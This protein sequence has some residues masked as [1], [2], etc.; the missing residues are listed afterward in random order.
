MPTVTATEAR[1]KLYRLIDQAASS[2]EP[3]IITGKRANAVLISED[4]W[5]AIQETLYLLSISGMRE[6]IREGL[7]TPIEECAEDLDW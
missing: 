1:A 5:R 2:H 3:I 4:D 6:S 7:E